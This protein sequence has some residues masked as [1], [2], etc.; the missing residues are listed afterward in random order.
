MHYMCMMFGGIKT[1]EINDY[2]EKLGIM[3]FRQWVFSAYLKTPYGKR[4]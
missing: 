1:K 4:T 3:T 2:H